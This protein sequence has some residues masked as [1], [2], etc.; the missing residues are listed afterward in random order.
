MEG[1]AYHEIADTLGINE[2]QVQVYL[3]RARVAMRKQLKTMGYD[4][5]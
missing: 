5:Y 4:E 2:N 1:Y 3:F